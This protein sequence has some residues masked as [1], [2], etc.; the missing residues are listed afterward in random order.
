MDHPH[1]KMVKDLVLCS[2]LLDFFPGYSL[3][4]RERGT[5]YDLVALLS[6]V[7]VGERL[8]S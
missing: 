8:S 1:K 4:G 7:A 2:L 3:M 6:C 5:S